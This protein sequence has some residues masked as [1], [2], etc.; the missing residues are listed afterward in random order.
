MLMSLAAFSVSAV[1]GGPDAL[2]GELTVMLPASVPIVEL[3]VLM[4]TDVPAFSAVWITPTL[5]VD[6][7]VPAR[8]LGDSPSSTPVVA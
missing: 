7:N 5:T 1:P 8:K 2:M 3:V 6:D 4:V